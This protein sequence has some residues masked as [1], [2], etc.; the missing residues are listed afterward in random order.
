[1]KK[2]ILAIAAVGISILLL[3]MTHQAVTP[4]TAT[5]DDV[6]REARTGGY[7][8]ITTGEL[9]NLYQQQPG[10]FLLVDTRQEWE[11]K[12]GHI[13][14]A[15]TFPMEPTAFSRWKKKDTLKSF[16][17]PDLNKSIIFY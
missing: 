9:K 13:K 8:L 10:S 14:D 3:W 17:G 5:W 7:R 11:Y 2:N 1:M 4:R 6:L 12:A 16:L 15:L